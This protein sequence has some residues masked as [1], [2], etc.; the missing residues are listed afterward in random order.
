VAT[1]ICERVGKPTSLI[2]RVKYRHG[3]DRRYAIDTGKLRQLGW[4]PRQEFLPALD[5]TIDWYTQNPTWWQRARSE[6]FRKYYEQQYKTR[7]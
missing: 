1:R 6:D 5:A 3:H 2:R 4:V 7:W